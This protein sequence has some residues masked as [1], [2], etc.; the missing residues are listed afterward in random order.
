MV[1][2]LRLQ[3]RIDRD[4]QLARDERQ[5]REQQHGGACQLVHAH[6]GTQPA[7]R[8]DAQQSDRDEA[9]GDVVIVQVPPGL[10]V[11]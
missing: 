10:P 2:R 1:T 4:A 9:K 6:G 11:S 8:C 7:G 3:L 5:Q